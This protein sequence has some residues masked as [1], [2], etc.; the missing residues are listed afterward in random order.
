MEKRAADQ[1]GWKNHNGYK[2]EKKISFRNRKLELLFYINREEHRVVMEYLKKER[3]HWII[4]GEPEKNP[5]YC[6]L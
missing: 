6:A 3:S 2:K 5:T 4:T 1:S